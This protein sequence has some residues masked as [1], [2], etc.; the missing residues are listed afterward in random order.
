MLNQIPLKVPRLKVAID[1]GGNMEN[2]D[3]ALFLM[4]SGSCQ[5][6]LLKSTSFLFYEIQKGFLKDW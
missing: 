6:Q 2:D 5:H 1:I 4:Y 3:H